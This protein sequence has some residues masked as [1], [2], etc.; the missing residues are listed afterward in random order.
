MLDAMHICRA[1]AQF[2]CSWSQYNPILAVDCLQLFGH[3][4][5]SIGAAIV[6]HDY[7]IVDFTGI[8]KNALEQQIT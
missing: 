8:S 1:Q 7:L 2:R 6:N 3:I 4:E 5:C